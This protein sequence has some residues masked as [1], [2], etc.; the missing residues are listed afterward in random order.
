M[1]MTREKMRGAASYKATKETIQKPRPTLSWWYLTGA[2]IDADWHM[3]HCRGYSEEEHFADVLVDS[4]E[5]GMS[6]IH[7]MVAD[8]L[9][10]NRQPVH[11]NDIVDFISKRS[12]SI[13]RGDGAS[14]QAKNRMAVESALQRSKIIKM[15][16]SEHYLL[17]DGSIDSKTSSEKKGNSLTPVDDTPT[18]HQSLPD[19]PNP[20]YTGS[21]FLRLANEN[22]TLT[23]LQALIIEVL[24]QHQGK[25]HVDN[26]CIHVARHWGSLKKRDGAPYT[27]DLRREVMAT[28]Q[29]K[30]IVRPIFKRDESNYQVYSLTSEARKLLQSISIN[31]GSIRFARLECDGDEGEDSQGE[32]GDE[33]N[34]SRDLEDDDT[35]DLDIDEE[36]DV[37]PSVSTSTGT[38][39][40][41]LQVLLIR[42]LAHYE[43][44]GPCPLEYI[45]QFVRP[46]WKSLRRRDGTSYSI[47]VMRGCLTSLNSNPSIPLFK[48]VSKD[49][50]LW[51]LEKGGQEQYDLIRKA[52]I[53][54]G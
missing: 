2:K 54:A 15:T 48:R 30:T 6:E 36:D 23:E 1:P 37:T 53:A 38:Y 9:R 13:R 47:D 14:D 35:N 40:T 19:P 50:S 8:Y 51:K 18:P 32:G 5:G 16:K 34:V 12:Q 7:G 42:A 20:N 41:D 31:L 4:H 10:S 49:P 17:E 24:A 39:L 25:S 3:G 27:A 44:E 52:E 22:P 29:S 45:V 43:P 11:I 21:F 28:L 33:E 26:I 46:Y